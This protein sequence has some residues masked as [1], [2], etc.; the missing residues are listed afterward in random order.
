MKGVI[1]VLAM[2]REKNL[3]L[4]KAAAAAVVAPTVKAP[5]VI[6]YT[7]KRDHFSVCRFIFECGEYIQ[8]WLLKNRNHGYD[9]SF[10]GLKLD[11]HPLTIST[12]AILYHRFMRECMPQ[13]YD[14]F[15]SACMID[16]NEKKRIYMWIICSW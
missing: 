14:P 11:A 6:D 15:V 5:I 7:K 10:L 9:F 4:M 3:S 12:A 13:G 1:D 16:E 2:Q 8:L